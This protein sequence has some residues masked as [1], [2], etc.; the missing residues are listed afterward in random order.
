MQAMDKIPDLRA[1]NEIT[2]EHCYM[3]LEKVGTAVST[4][5]DNVEYGADIVNGIDIQHMKDFYVEMY[6]PNNF[7]RLYLTVFGQGVLVGSY[8]NFLFSYVLSNTKGKFDE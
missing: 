6:T 4:M 7:T 2:L 5:E 3:L 1:D 8:V